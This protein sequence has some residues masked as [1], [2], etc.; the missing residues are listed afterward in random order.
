MVDNK[1]MPMLMDES[2]TCSFGVG[3]YRVVSTACTILMESHVRGRSVKFE[4]SPH[5]AAVCH[6]DASYIP[7][8]HGITQRQVHDSIM[9]MF[10]RKRARSLATRPIGKRGHLGKLGLGYT[11][12]ELSPS[13]KIIMRAMQIIF[14]TGNGKNIPEQT[15]MACGY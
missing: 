3:I 10:I 11:I 6:G 7:A 9:P 4:P 1:I 2:S 14:H 15:L 8:L 13:K 5:A 12:L